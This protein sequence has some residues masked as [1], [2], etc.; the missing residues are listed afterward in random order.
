MFFLSDRPK[1]KP[2]KRVKKSPI[3][4]STEANATPVNVE[5]MSAVKTEAKPEAH[6]AD[7]PTYMESIET[8]VNASEEVMKTESQPATQMKVNNHLPYKDHQ[9]SRITFYG[10]GETEEPETVIKDEKVPIQPKI[11]AKRSYGDPM[12]IKAKTVNKPPPQSFPQVIRPTPIIYQWKPNNGVPQPALVYFLPSAAPSTSSN[13]GY[14]APV[15][16]PVPKIDANPTVPLHFKTPVAIVQ[17]SL[18]Q[19]QP[20][21]YVHFHNPQK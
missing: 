10:S 1:L 15:S 18:M 9:Y 4:I 19:Q 3:K 17:G 8:I 16:R 7:Y 6:K 2:T 21:Y 14:I 11:Q 13:V 5:L 20:I 12:V